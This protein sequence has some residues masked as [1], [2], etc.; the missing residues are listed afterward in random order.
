MNA[1]GNRLVGFGERR[2]GTCRKACQV[3][4]W[5]YGCASWQWKVTIWQEQF[6]GRF[7]N[8]FC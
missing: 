2:M 7:L 1:M 6:W 4:G 3:R 5:R 8:L